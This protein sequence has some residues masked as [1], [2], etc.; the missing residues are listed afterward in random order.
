MRPT[1]SRLTDIIFEP[2]GLNLGQPPMDLPLGQSPFLEN[3]LVREGGFEPRPMLS[4]NSSNPQPMPVAVLGG[5]QVQDVTGG[6]YH[7]ASG[8]TDFAWYSANSWSRLSY[9]TAGGISD[10]PALSETQYWDYTQIYDP[11]SDQNVAIAAP[12]SHQSLYVWEAGTTVFSTLTQAP[13]AKY[14]T[15]YDNYVLALNV[16]DPASSNSTYVQRVQWSDRGDPANWTTGLSGF[17]DLLDMR[18]QGTRIIND[19]YR[20][21]VF[22]DSEIWQGI[23]GTPPFQFSFAPV[24]R[25]VG[26]PY[27]W[28]VANTPVGVI[29]LGRDL[30]LYLLPKGGGPAQA[31]AVDEIGPLLQSEVDYPERAWAVYDVATDTYQL[32]YVPRGSDYPGRAL[33]FRVIDQSWTKQTYD[34]T[35]GPRYLSRGWTGVRTSA[36]TGLTWSDISGNYTWQT[37]PFT[38]AQMLPT[39]SAVNPTVFVGSSDGTIYYMDSDATTDD[40]TPV[41]T[42]W[43]SG[44]VGGQQPGQNKRVSQVRLDYKADAASQVTVG[45]S[46]DGGAT[47]GTSQS[48]TL[49]AGTQVQQ[50]QI[51]VDLDSLYPQVVISSENLR[52]KVRRITVSFRPT[53][54][55]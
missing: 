12:G 44:S 31:F 40:G 2:G 41:E 27:S 35:A 52:G 55:P 4:S 24:D 14:V 53:G 32:T 19:E 39:Q 18:G 25:A 48:V 47:V 30:N 20:V 17:E 9:V 54:R 28:T 37:L 1:T 8:T 38:W 42:K 46:G 45:V 5:T 49:M 11:V 50:K 34:H 3:V 15:A 36:T 6:I 33:W 22:S 21:L 29:F 10:P 51:D 43:R 16:R 13:R 7:L 23:R 26:A